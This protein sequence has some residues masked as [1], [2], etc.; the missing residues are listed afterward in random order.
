MQRPAWHA[1]EEP[2][3]A[4]CPG[5]ASATSRADHRGSSGRALAA[6]PGLPD[7]ALVVRPPPSTQP[8]EAAP[9]TGAGGRTGAAGA[10]L[11]RPD[12]CSDTSTPVRRVCSGFLP[13]TLDALCY[14]RRCLAPR[15]G[16]GRRPHPFQPR[17]GCGSL[18]GPG[19]RP[20]DGS[21]TS[22]RTRSTT[23]VLTS[24]ASSATTAAAKTTTRTRANRSERRTLNCRDG[25]GDEPGGWR[26]RCPPVAVDP[27][28]RRAQ[29]AHARE[30][31]AQARRR[32]C[33]VP[34]LPCSTCTGAAPSLDGTTPAGRPLP[35]GR[36]LRHARARPLTGDRALGGD[37][38]P[39]E[40]SVILGVASLAWQAWT[41]RH[42]GEAH[43]SCEW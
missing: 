16:G 9:P 36:V 23:V 35:A 30:V 26:W 10:R 21:I 27:P 28:S 11:R 34:D 13:T 31:D 42:G 37:A 25:R 14:A 29:H 18:A 40:L 4:Q 41:W 38:R 12:P 15:N 17:S 19:Q 3:N 8:Q 5:A 1:E 22:C 7:E 6:A 33:P 20:C 2:G 39:R 43:S 32:P 24:H